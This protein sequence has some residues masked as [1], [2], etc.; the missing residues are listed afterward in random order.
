MVAL[1][2]YRATVAARATYVPSFVCRESPRGVGFEVEGGGEGGGR[3]G[4]GG[5]GEEGGG[6]IGRVQGVARG[7]LA[8]VSG[9]GAAV[10]VEL[11]PASPRYRGGRETVVGTRQ[12]TAMRWEH[13]LNS[14]WTIG[15]S[16]GQRSS[17]G[18]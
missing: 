11:G 12:L 18:V 7:G 17:R 8:G 3:R 6:E 15:G 5:D 2:T 16:K 1:S 4:S 10:V 13:R 14:K 9:F